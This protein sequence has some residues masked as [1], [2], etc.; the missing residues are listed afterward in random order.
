MITSLETLKNQEKL[1]VGIITHVED[2]KERV[3]RKLE[4]YAAVPGES[5]TVVK[6]V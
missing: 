3:P 1:K 6:M 4:V 5:G 2:I